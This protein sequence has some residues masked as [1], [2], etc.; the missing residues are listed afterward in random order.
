ME[1]NFKIKTINIKKGID[2]LAVVV[3]VEAGAGIRKN[4]IRINMLKRKIKI[5]KVINMITI[6]KEE[7]R[8]IG[9]KNSLM[10]ILI[11]E[12]SIVFSRIIIVNLF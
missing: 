8:A 4:L 2:I 3:I 5:I 7:L 10:T 11:I 9:I 12:I 6:M 1:M